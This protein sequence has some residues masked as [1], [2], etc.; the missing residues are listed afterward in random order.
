[1]CPEAV[2]DPV[3]AAAVAVV[4]HLEEGPDAVLPGG[5]DG[6]QG[7]EVPAQRRVDG[8]LVRVIG[9]V[10]GELPGRLL[11]EVPGEVTGQSAH[12]LQGRWG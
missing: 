9:D 12:G 2:T 8:P 10:T 6:Q 1:M 5:A 3:D 7:R 11:P 4:P